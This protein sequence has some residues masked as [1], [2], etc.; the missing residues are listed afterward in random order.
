MKRVI[1]K[2]TFPF[3]KEFELE[4]PEDAYILDVQLQNSIPALWAIC[5][6][7]ARKEIRNFVLVGTGQEF[8]LTG[9]NY[10]G[11]FQI[12]EFVW[13]LFE[14]LIAAKRFN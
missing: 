5:N 2:F 3:K 1:W 8:N 10:I 13:H 9:L 4:M 6:T 12:E 7:E 14:E 11:T